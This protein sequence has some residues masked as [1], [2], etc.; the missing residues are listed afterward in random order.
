MVQIGDR[1]W[2]LAHEPKG[3]LVAYLD[4]FGS[5]LLEQGFKQKHLGPQIRVAANFSRWLRAKRVAVMDIADEHARSFLQTPRMRRSIRQGGPAALRRLIEFLCHRDIICKRAE[6]TDR[7]PVEQVIDRYSAY[8][9]QEQGLCDKTLIQYCP[10]I[11]CFLA[12]RFGSGPVNLAMLCAG[13]VV[14]FV[15]QQAARLSPARG[16][17]ATIA[18]RSFLRYLRCRGEIQ[19]DLVAAVP[20]VPNWSMTGIPRAIAVDHIHAAL[21]QCQRDTPAGNRDYAILLLLARL[22]LRSSEIVS[23]TLDSVDWVEGSI[24]VQGKGGR[25]TRLPLPVE[26][27]EAIAC[28]LRQ[29]RSPC[30]N[31]ALFLRVNAP[32]RG[33]GS[34]TTIG[35]IVNAALT[36]A[37]ITTP[38]RGAHQFRH[39]LAADMLRHGATLAEIGSLLRH[40]HPKTTGIYAKVDFAALRPLGLPW[41]GG[42]L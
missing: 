42:A 35:T 38:H 37:G 20:T 24:A 28:Y 22:G 25:A 27:G 36:R 13:D 29:G 21:A 2:V 11:A 15:R 40:R 9:Q 31:R 6:H 17:A 26:V 1:P 4:P 18:L 39:A 5:Y 34:P 33:L 16:K 8:L 23:L 32:V 19:L 12:E 10:F 30:R 7:T 41:P 3:P 14:G